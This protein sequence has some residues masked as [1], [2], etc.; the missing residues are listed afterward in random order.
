MWGIKRRL[1]IIGIIL[2]AI[3]ILG[4]F[5]YWITHRE[6][7][8]CFDGKQNQEE[9]GVDCGGPCTLLCKGDADDLKILWT[10][11]FPVRQGVYDVVAYIENPNFNVA[12]PEFSYTA[13]LYDEDKTLIIEEK[14]AS[15][16]LPSE[17][18]AIFAGGLRTGEKKAVSGSI[19]IT[20][21]YQWQK[22]EQ[23]DDL[24]SV[25]D[26]VLTGADRKPKLAAVLHN[27]TPDLYRDINAT[28]IIYAHRTDRKW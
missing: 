18:F 20:S 12:V 22:T 25:T 8:T 13:K 27:D 17:R 15:F 6:K 7:P 19:E 4:V 24:F 23:A 1:E 21:G 26:R 11:V 14:G 16:A 3:L 28:A 10:K 5:P 2:V 9:T